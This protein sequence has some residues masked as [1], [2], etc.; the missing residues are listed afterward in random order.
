MAISRPFL[1]ALLG[2]ALLG[3]TFLAVQN[4]RD[5][6]TDVPAPAAQ[7]Q[8]PA[9]PA[10]QPAPPADPAETLRAAFDVAAI[11]STAFEAEL[12]MSVDAEPVSVK[13]SGAFEKGA[14][15]D[16]PELALEARVAADGERLQG[17]FVAV[18]DKAYFTQGD[19]GWQVPDEVWRPLVE[20]VESGAGAEAQSLSLP[21][22][23][24]GWVRD[25]EAE[26]T[27]TVD[28]VEATHISASVD[29]EAMVKDLTRAARQNGAQLPA[30]T[31]FGEVVKQ[32]ELDA[33]V[34][35]DDKVLRRLRAEV[36]FAATGGGE[37]GPGRLSFELEL[38][39]VNKPQEIEAPAK[40]RQG[41]P[42]GAFGQFV[43][44]FSTGLAGVG[45]GE[46]VSL[47]ALTSRNPQRAA[48]AVKAG[49][50]V[51]VL[52]RNPRGLDDRAMADV[53][54]ALDRRTRALVLTDHVDA[55]ERYGQMVEDVG[56]SQT[57]SV[58]LIDRAGEA[59]L[60][61]GYVDTDTLAQAVSDAR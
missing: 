31:G 3:A 43:Q 57:P 20:A 27:E 58:V 42:A 45:G 1:L 19:S 29:P 12:S 11:D 5:R 24:A 2:A 33:W 8:Q 22:D 48:R 10:E 59:R 15:N 32:A 40:V 49:N 41:L 54:R 56:V 30:G 47:A 51:V 28:G 60:I 9:T 26:G 55:V 44:G 61:E 52:F 17:G 13:L 37:A 39:G 18:D 6:T 50:K 53:M 21:V 38:T 34:G 36:A 25:I 35:E 7:E 14:V 23:P 4:A 46:P 16:I